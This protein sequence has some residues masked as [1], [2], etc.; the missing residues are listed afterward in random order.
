MKGNKINTKIKV[1]QHIAYIYTL[2]LYRL[3]NLSNT[4]LFLEL[5]I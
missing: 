1:V 4:D 5:Y 2:K 3:H